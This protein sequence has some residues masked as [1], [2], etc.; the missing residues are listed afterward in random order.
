MGSTV[1]VTHERVASQRVTVISK[2][3]QEAH[4]GINQRQH[5]QW[6]AE[7]R[8]PYLRCLAPRTQPPAQRAA[9]PLAAAAHATG[10]G[11]PLHRSVRCLRRLGPCRCTLPLALQGSAPR[12]GRRA[13]WK[14]GGGG[15][16]RCRC[17]RCRHRCRRSCAALQLGCT[18]GPV[19]I[20]R[21]RC[22][23]PAGV[24]HR[25]AMAAPGSLRATVKL[26]YAREPRSATALAAEGLKPGR[27]SCHDVLG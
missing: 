14:P 15:R 23:S 22:R 25:A 26:T 4:C 12:Q 10:T 6:N 5:A 11:P 1:I 19:S 16:V 17:H 21:G 3:C 7:P 13:Q 9:P 24:L 20:Q 27:M 2:A 18:L 8:P